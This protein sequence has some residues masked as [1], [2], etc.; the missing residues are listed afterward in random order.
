MGKATR[1]TDKTPK[2]R[3]PK[4]KAIRGMDKFLTRLATGASV[5][6]AA[7]GTGVSRATLYAL[8]LQD[9]EFRARWDEAV[10]KGTDVLE[11]L[12]LKRARTSDVLI[13]FL[14]KARR[15]ER[16][17]DRVEITDRKLV[18]CEPRFTK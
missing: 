4:P 6:G 17:K 1:K 7:R 8:R 14:L 3:T 12:A 2:K 15:P 9:E 13:I 18:E 5:T 10:E 11:D 16:Y